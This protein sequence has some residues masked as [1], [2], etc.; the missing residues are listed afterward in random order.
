MVCLLYDRRRKHRGLSVV[1]FMG[2]LAAH[3]LVRFSSDQF[4]S[5]GLLSDSQEHRNDWRLY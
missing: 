5:T 2:Q 3:L 4:H 1:Y